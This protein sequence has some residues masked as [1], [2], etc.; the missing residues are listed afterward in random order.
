MLCVS[1]LFLWKLWEALIILV[2]KLKLRDVKWFSNGY[3]RTEP[4][5]PWIVVYYSLHYSVNPFFVVDMFLK[6]EHVFPALGRW[7]CRNNA[8][9]GKCQLCYNGHPFSLTKATWDTDCGG[10][11]VECEWNED[12]SSKGFP[13]HV[14]A[15][16]LLLKLCL[17]SIK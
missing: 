5:I 4:K 13:N 10:A 2:D 7:G 6:G 14:P 15:A 8:Y 11:W 17:F 3:S 16:I 12:R 9:L 1:G